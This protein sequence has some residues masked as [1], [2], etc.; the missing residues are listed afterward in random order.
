MKLN[1][2]F[3]E[4]KAVVV[5]EQKLKYFDSFLS[6]HFS[7][8]KYRC[9]CIDNTI[10][11]F[12]NLNEVIEYENPDFRRIKSIEIFGDNE[13][14]ENKYASDIYL[15]PDFRIELGGNWP[16]QTLKYTIRSTDISK[17]TYFEKE[18]QE[19]IKDFRPWYWVISKTSFNTVL[20]VVSWS[21]TLIAG[22]S[23]LKQRISGKT[24]PSSNLDL[25]Y[26]GWFF[27]IISSIGIFIGLI[28]IMDK[29]KNYLFPKVVI[30]LGKQKERSSKKNNIIYLVFG[31]I[32][33]SVLINLFSSWI[34]DYFTKK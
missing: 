31:V 13:S 32:I 6:E 22:F 18:L 15:Y 27:L 7:R 8:K 24:V 28:Y 16:F 30:K 2:E 23:S 25:T 4:N 26:N 9:D 17:T 1:K 5:D 12:D 14:S 34:W 19:R 21:Y 10:I 3:K 11:E 29:F 20:W 33:L